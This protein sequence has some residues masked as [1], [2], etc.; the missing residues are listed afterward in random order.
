MTRLP[1]RWRLTV[2]YAAFLAALLALFGFGLYFGLRHILY[3]NFSDQVQSNSA[4]AL[5][6]VR[7]DGDQTS[8]I[9]LDPST[10]TSLRS[11]ER[12][13][14]LILPDGTVVVDTS[15]TVGGIPIDPALIRDALAGVTQRT[16]AHGKDGTLAVVTAPVYANGAVAGVLQVGVSRGDTDEVLRDLLIVLAIVSPIALAAAAGLGYVLARRALAPVAA[17]TRTAATIGAND[18][19]ARLSLP[20]PDDELGRLARTFDAMLARIEDA[21]ERQRQFTGD[22]AHELRTPLSLM[23]SQVDLALS[24]PRS[25]EAYQVALADL[26]QDLERLTDLVGTLLTLSRADSGRLPLDRAP[27]DLADTT[28][29]L[30]EQYVPL[31]DEA[32]IAL[33]DEST[34]SP[35]VADEDLLIQVL[36]NL[37]D[38][39]LAHTSAGGR[40][41]VGCRPDGESVRL[42]VADTG[43]GIPAEHLSHVFDRFYRVD[44]GR[45]RAQGGAGLGLAIAKAIAESHG[46]AINLESQEGEGTRVELMLPRGSLPLP[47][48]VR[49]PGTELPL[50]AAASHAD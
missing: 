39:A 17:I 31:A 36:V 22:A 20:L 40:I 48:D 12:F 10:V 45:A 16:S 19:H 44:T 1:I 34:P 6:A 24:R 21:F 32:G 37:L 13:V 23:R 15:D 28:A 7:T 46:G 30:L 4:L 43:T 14:R 38:N 25:V 11:D 29:L 18:L 9:F 27:M 26:N 8:Q 41:R 33:L 2:W 35:L 50:S 49:G 5:A 42:W 47:A 3:G